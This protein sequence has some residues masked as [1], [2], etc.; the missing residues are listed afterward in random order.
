MQW[1]AA[2]GQGNANRTHLKWL[3]EAIIPISMTSIIHLYRLRQSCGPQKECE[4]AR[5]G[6]KLCLLLFSLLGS[7]EGGE[8]YIV[9]LKQHKTQGNSGLEGQIHY[10]SYPL[11]NPAAKWYVCESGG[12]R[13][14]LRLRNQQ[15][16]NEN[17]GKTD[18]RKKWGRNQNIWGVQWKMRGNEIKGEVGK[19][20]SKWNVY[21]KSV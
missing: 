19:N 20:P 13:Y 8:K 16:A 2:G 7:G 11:W 15:G 4:Q 10:V 3:E 5:T 12:S 6:E 9:K 21:E 14:D 1:R 17:G 18:L